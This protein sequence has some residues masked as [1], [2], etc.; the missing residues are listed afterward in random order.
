MYRS[1]WPL[2]PLNADIALTAGDVGIIWTTAS[3]LASVNQPQFYMFQVELQS[4]V[5]LCLPFPWRSLP[6]QSHISR[7]IHRSHS[8]GDFH[9][10]LRLENFGRDRPYFG[11]RVELASASVA[12]LGKLANERFIAFAN[13]VS[14]N[15]IWTEAFSADGIEDVGAAVVFEDVAE[16]LGQN[17]GEDVVRVFRGVL[18]P[19]DVAEDAPDPRF[20][21]LVT[22]GFV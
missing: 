4:N 1:G 16:M 18:G 20:V 10:G 14:F 8:W 7:G 21:G 19:A 17:E 6:S 3:S 9:P 2:S 13:N 12:T 22:I 11:W 15:V 5:L